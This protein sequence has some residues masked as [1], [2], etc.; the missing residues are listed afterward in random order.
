MLEELGRQLKIRLSMPLPGKDAHYRM[1]N[2]ERR[3]NLSKYSIPQ[4][5][6]WSG[7]L[8]ML[9]QDEEDIRFPLIIRKEDGSVHGGQVG[10][11]GGKF[12]PSDL[13]LSRTALR[14]TEE[15]IGIASDAIQLIGKLTELYIPPS[16]FLVHPYIGV[17]EGTPRFIPD[18]G[19]VESVLEFGLEDLLNDELIRE[20]QITLST[21]LKIISPAIEYKGR[22]IW[23]ATAMMLSELK[24]I[25]MEMGY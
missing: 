4:H 18:P 5:A 8:I 12:E 9:Y 17:Y 20:K 6:R 11:P 2:E 10:L 1:A 22:T 25:L 15:E 13:E 14:E 21:G 23:G 16:N 7:V 24:A 3:L 19:E